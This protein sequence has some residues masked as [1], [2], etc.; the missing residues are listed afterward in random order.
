M[1][2]LWIGKTIFTFADNSLK[3]EEASSGSAADRII[4]K[5]GRSTIEPDPFAPSSEEPTL[6][7]ALGRIHKRLSNPEELKKLHLQHHDMTTDQFRFRT[8][9]LHLPKS[10]FD[11]FDKI[12]S[13]CEVCQA[14]KHAPSR[15]KTS[16]LRADTFGDM[17]FIDHCQVPL[18]TGKHII[19]FVILD[20][21]TT[22]PTAEA[23][24]TTQEVENITV[25]RNFFDQ[26]HLQPNSVVADQAFMTETIPWHHTDI[27]GT[28][29]T[30][31]KSS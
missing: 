31:A 2:N 26:Y 30:M 18:G 10:T 27:I 15:S 4:D 22:L 25:P 28:E 14:A 23:V 12:R 17:T 8:R 29:Y 7:L 19:V 13:E 21:A 16:G 3:D 20:G 1:I 6:P 5:K 9:S 24:T 11:L